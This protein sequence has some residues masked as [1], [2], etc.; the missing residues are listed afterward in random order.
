MKKIL[1]NQ[2]GFTMVELAVVILIIG[3]LMA[4]FVPKVISSGK[5]SATKGAAS[6][7][8]K[9]GTEVA[10][11]ASIF[12]AKNFTELPVATGLAD[13]VT[14]NQMST[15]TPLEKWK[16]SAYSGTYAYV[17]DNTSYTT[18][19]GTAAADTVLIL[20]GITHDIC[21]AIDVQTGLITDGA[22]PPGSITNNADPQCFGSS[23]SYR[24]V[25]LIYQH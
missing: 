11:Q 6:N 14:N 19:F 15:I 2:R 20:D 18:Q 12:A 24:F 16:D 5:E 4:I 21:Q 10:E 3:V 13:L 17:L 9:N 23:G 7:I 25:K 8:V 1:K 22:E